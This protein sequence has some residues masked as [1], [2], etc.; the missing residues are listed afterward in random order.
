M[1]QLMLLHLCAILVWGLTLNPLINQ[2]STDDRPLRLRTDLVVIDLLPVQKKTGRVLADLTR[3]DIELF[4]DGVKQ[5]I[6]HFSK[7]AAPVSI[8][9]LIDR[10]GCV[11]AFN[12]QIRDATVEAISRLKPED[13]VAIMTFSNKVNLAQPFTRDRR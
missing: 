6:S 4:E 8:L 1:N 11:N 12:E 5:I 13:E 7:G 2:E 9:L 3:D 10:A